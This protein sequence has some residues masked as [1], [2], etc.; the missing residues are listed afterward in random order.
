MLMNGLAFAIF[1]LQVSATGTYLKREE[2]PSNRRKAIVSI[3]SKASLT[4]GTKQAGDLPYYDLVVVVPA[5]SSKDLARREAIRDSWM[6]YMGSDG[7]CQRCNSKR[8]V[9]VLFT[10]GQVSNDVDKV[11]A[12]ASKHNDI[13]VLPD[14]HEDKDVY[15]N[16]ANK[17]R[18]SIAYAV[19]HY[20][21]SMLLKADTDSYVFMDRLLYFLDKQDLWRGPG[22]Q[23]DGIYAGNFKAGEGAKPIEK[24]NNRWSDLIF[25][26]VTG[27]AFFP[28][29]AKGPGY[30]LSPSLCRFISE[31]APHEENRG[32]WAMLPQLDD[33]PNEDVAVGWWLEPVKHQKVELPVAMWATACSYLQNQD[34]RMPT[35]EAVIDHKV[36]P[37]LMRLRYAQFEKTGDACSSIDVIEEGIAETESGIALDEQWQKEG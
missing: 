20:M 24:P 19:D 25:R 15:T 17:V 16:L 13:G 18:R 27:H 32:G 12:E 31:W 34:P 22:D 14:F 4:S 11:A 35:N 6:R 21:F 1:F 30:L 36:D 28:K 3:D 29:H 33:L 23:R 8:T 7:V 9:K 26:K 2:P 5:H 10:L 37:K